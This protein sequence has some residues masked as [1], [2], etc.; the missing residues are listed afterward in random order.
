MRVLKARRRRAASSAYAEEEGE[1]DK[2]EYSYR[3]CSCVRLRL[4]R[5]IIGGIRGSVR[6]EA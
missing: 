6:R 1:E 2:E 4:L 5:G 3:R